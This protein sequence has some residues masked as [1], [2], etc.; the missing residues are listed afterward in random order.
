MVAHTVNARRG[1]RF[2][3][4]AG[5]LIFPILLA[6]AGT[7][8][9][10]DGVA[11]AKIH[12]GEDGLVESLTPVFYAITAVLY[13]T[14]RTRIG[15]KSWVPALILFLM[16]ARELDADKWFTA[17][18]LTST[19]YYFD[20]PGV[21]YTQRIAVG[22]VALGVAVAILHLFW[23][24]RWAI[25]RA[26]RDFRPYARS[27]LCGFFILGVSQVLDGLGRTVRWLAHT[28]LPS[29]Q[30]QLAGIGEETLELGVSLAFLIAL[31]QLVFGATRNELP[32]TASA[33]RKARDRRREPLPAR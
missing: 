29:A 20:N 27:L 6:W 2:F 23:K 22:I 3:D 24:N 5:V 13:L 8:C 31:L 7:L 17:K 12:F 19:G 9:L 18:S 1:Q 14:W 30:I 33:P 11:T 28:R 16:A 4:W 21:S 26:L 32:R 10:V 15:A 25:V